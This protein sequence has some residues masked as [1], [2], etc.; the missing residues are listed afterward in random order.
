MSLKRR[1]GWVLAAF[2]FLSIAL[3][4]QASSLKPR[5]DFAAAMASLI[6]TEKAKLVKQQVRIE[7]LTDL[8]ADQADQI[9]DLEDRLRALE[10]GDRKVCEERW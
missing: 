1:V 7:E 9:V 4:P 2:C 10:E 5:G 8:A 3:N 6:E